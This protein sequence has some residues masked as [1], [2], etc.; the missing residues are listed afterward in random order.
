MKG[1][2]NIALSK[3]EDSEGEGK[4]SD[5]KIVTFTSV[6]SV[7]VT[8]HLTDLF[9]GLLQLAY[10]PLA[11]TANSDPEHN[12][13]EAGRHTGSVASVDSLIIA[14]P[15]TIGGLAAI[16]V[17]ETDATIV[18]TSKDN[19]RPLAVSEREEIEWLFQDTFSRYT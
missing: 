7:I 19:D 12:A 2:Y 17:D 18:E 8:R 10:A 11:G 15:G 9:A 16:S 14:S 6:S 13:N 5:T 4:K 1:L 3:E